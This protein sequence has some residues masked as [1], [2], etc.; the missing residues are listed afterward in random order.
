[1]SN[2]EDLMEVIIARLK[3]PSERSKPNGDP[4]DVRQDG[5]R[6]NGILFLASRSGQS[7]SATITERGTDLCLRFD[8]EGTECL[9]KREELLG[10]LN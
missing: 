6:R 5:A 9:I 4:Y 1:M 3:I 10:K 7:V 8:D 2:L